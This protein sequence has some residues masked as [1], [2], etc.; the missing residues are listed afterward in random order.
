MDKASGKFWL[1][2]FKK[3]NVLAPFIYDADYY[4]FCLDFNVVF[5][6]EM[7]TTPLD[8]QRQ[9]PPPL[10]KAKL[11]NGVSTQSLT[12][13]SSSSQTSVLILFNMVT[14]SVGYCSISAHL[15][16][17]ATVL[18]NHILVSF[19]IPSTAHV[20]RTRRRCLPLSSTTFIICHVLLVCFAIAHYITCL[21]L[22]HLTFFTGWEKTGWVEKRQILFLANVSNESQ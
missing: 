13:S 20:T 21:I 17:R 3:K 22:M 2:T 10:R 6:W 9:S 8:F 1:K 18:V 16:S 14:R 12:P 19:I 5:H 7:T 4:Y 15:S 11:P